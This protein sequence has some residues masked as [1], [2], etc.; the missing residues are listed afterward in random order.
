[1]KIL[2]AIAITLAAASAHAE[3]MQKYL[4]DTQEMVRQGKHE[5]ALQ[6]FRWF[7]DHALEHD[8]AM[9]GVRLSFAL[10]Y[11][12]ALG[13][14]YPPARAALVETR[15]RK[16]KN[17]LQGKGTAHLFHDV[18]S[19][20]NT[21]GDDQKTVEL[22]RKL[23]AEQNDLA[24][25]CWDMAKDSI[26]KGKAY[27]LARKYIGNPVREWGKVQAMYE[28]HKAMYGGN[29]FGDHFKA[30]SE[31]RFVEESIKLIHVALALDDKKAAREIQKRALDIID[32]YRLNDA[33]PN[34]KEEDAQPEN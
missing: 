28:Q 19:L 1:M 7:H 23:D 4:S 22:F 21:L 33:I 25:Q 9:Y 32:D 5:E 30:Y 10:G 29:N 16:E 8:P 27:D 3:D 12:K 18:A 34:E 17:I 20:N 2:L 31:N 14:V 26:I 15:D 13:D 11:W 24:K 6:R